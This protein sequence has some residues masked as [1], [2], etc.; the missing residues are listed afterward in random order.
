MAEN[1]ALRAVARVLRDANDHALAVAKKALLPDADHQEL[2]A[3]VREV[4]TRARTLVD[5]LNGAEHRKG[6]E[7]Q[8]AEILELEAM[9]AVGFH[10][11]SG[12]AQIRWLCAQKRKNATLRIV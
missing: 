11:L 4:L 2:L 5:S 1:D 6:F 12:E 7:I 3:K 10:M 9:D 8:D